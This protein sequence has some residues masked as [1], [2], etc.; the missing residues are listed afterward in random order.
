[1]ADP[2]L[3]FRGLMDFMTV[4]L[5][6]N[7]GAI[8]VQCEGELARWQRHSGS[9]YTHESQQTYYTGDRGF[10]QIPYL[11]NRRIDWRKSNVWQSAPSRG[12]GARGG[13]SRVG[14]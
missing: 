10:D 3:V 13:P 14:R 1:V 9:L 6:A 5:G 4:E 11:Q 8:V 7:S 12:G 2:Q